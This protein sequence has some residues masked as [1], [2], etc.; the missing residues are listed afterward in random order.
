[1]V[2]VGCLEL[3]E[4]GG[5]AM[6]NDMSADQRL[7]TVRAAK[8]KHETA[9]LRLHGVHG[10]GVGFKEVG[11]EPTEDLAIVVLVHCKKKRSE[12]ALDDLVPEKVMQRSFFGEG[13]EEVATDVQE[14]AQPF[15]S[16]TSRW[17]TSP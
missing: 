5:T 7:A 14:R 12:I 9:L 17:P 11:G 1:M 15:P 10:V 3:R 2:L 8:A 16:A 13:V 4:E 6:A